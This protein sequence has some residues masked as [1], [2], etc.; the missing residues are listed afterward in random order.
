M[1]SEHITFTTVTERFGWNLK[2]ARQRVGLTQQEL[3]A[4]LG[5][6][7]SCDISVWETGKQ[8]PRIDTVVRLAEALEIEPSELLRET[9]GLGPSS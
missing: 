5:M 6:E 7:F 2:I 1:P 4:R 3:A 8:C 9:R